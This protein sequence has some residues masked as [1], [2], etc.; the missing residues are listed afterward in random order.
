VRPRAARAK[1]FRLFFDY[2]SGFLSG[3]RRAQFQFSFPSVGQ[4]AGSNRVSGPAIQQPRRTPMR[5]AML[6][7]ACAAGLTLTAGNASADVKFGYSSYGSSPVAS[8]YPSF[9]KPFISVYYPTLYPTFFPTPTYFPGP[10]FVTPKPVY[11]WFGAGYSGSFF[12]SK[13]FQ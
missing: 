9:L 11:P 4:N 2:L 6:T 8:S 12:Y 7:L 13:N 1:G 5:A 10:Y 3:N